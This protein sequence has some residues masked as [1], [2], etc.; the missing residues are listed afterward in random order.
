MIA[1]ALDTGVS[2]QWLATGKGDQQNLLKGDLAIPKMFLKTGKLED[3]VYWETDLSF[4]SHNY[5]EPTFIYNNSG[6][7]LVDLD[8]R[9][10]SNGRWILGIDDKYDIY[11]VILLP[12]KKISVINNGS[13]FSCGIDEVTAKGKVVITMEYNF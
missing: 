8:V 9:D 6:S 2:L 13:S 10:I 12:G 11:D 3:A 7:W 1:C 4:I 5:I